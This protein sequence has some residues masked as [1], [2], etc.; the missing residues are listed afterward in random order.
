MLLWSPKIIK[1]FTLP[2][3]ERVKESVWAEI[4]L[5]MGMGMK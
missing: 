4:I 1:I 2:Q 3:K 5:P